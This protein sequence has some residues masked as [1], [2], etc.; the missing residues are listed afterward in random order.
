MVSKVRGYACEECGEIFYEESD[1][2]ECEGRH[3]EE[4]R[5]ERE[6]EER[7]Q[8]EKEDAF[9]TIRKDFL[10]IAA[11]LIDK[12]QKNKVVVL[13]VGIAKLRFE[14]LWGDESCL[15]VGFLGANLKKGTSPVEKTISAL[16]S[17]SGE[18]GTYYLEQYLRGALYYTDNVEKFISLLEDLG[19]DTSKYT[20]A[21]DTFK[22]NLDK[23]NNY[24]NSEIQYELMDLYMWKG[25]EEVKQVDYREFEGMF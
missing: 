16:L 6:Q 9:E 8:R 11:P 1:A 23:L 25:K 22:S 17:V 21:R 24:M 5:E 12:C 18:D 14:L 2:Y 20:K 7:D 13:D 3:E 10:K 4:D 19:I 15:E